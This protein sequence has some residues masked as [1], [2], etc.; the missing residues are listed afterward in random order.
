MFFFFLFPLL[1]RL[2]LLTH[3]HT[4]WCRSS[5]SQT[6]A[7]REAGRANEVLAAQTKAALATL[8]ATQKSRPILLAYE[9]VW[10]IGDTGIPATADYA[11]RGRR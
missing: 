6:L 11:D 4:A 3:M 1:A 2:V 9:P 8:D 5:A 10:A 7:E